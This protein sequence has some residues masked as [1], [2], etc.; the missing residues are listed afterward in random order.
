MRTMFEFC[1]LL[2]EIDIRNF[3]FTNVFSSLNFMAS[4]SVKIKI[5]VN[6]SAA[7]RW[8]RNKIGP[9]VGTIIVLNPDP[10]TETT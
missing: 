2:E 5:T 4:V 6:D 9:N 10:E 7:E 3:N 8:I 1:S